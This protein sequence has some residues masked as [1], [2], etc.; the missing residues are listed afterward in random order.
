MGPRRHLR[1]VRL[2]V[3]GV[4]LVAW[5]S[6]AGF[7][8]A[9]PTAVPKAAGPKSLSPLPSGA[10]ATAAPTGPPVDVSVTLVLELPKDA[11]GK[12]LPLKLGDQVVASFVVEAPANVRVF[13][14]SPPNFGATYRRLARIATVTDLPTAAGRK[15][16]QHSWQL[17]VVRRGAKRL[18]SFEVPWRHVDGRTGSVQTNVIRSR[19]RGRLSNEQDPK[20][21]KAPAPA[22]V[23]ATNWALIWGLALLGSALLAGLL[24]FLGL[25]VYRKRLIALQP[26]PPPQPANVAALEKLDEAMASTLKPADRYAEIID[27]LR[28]YLGERYGFDGLE[29]TTKEMRRALDGAD[30]GDFSPY[31]ITEQ[32]EDADLVKF[33]RMSPGEGE[34]QGKANFVRDLVEKT[35]Q[36]PEPDTDEDMVAALESA[37]VRERLIAG[38]VD[39]GVAGLVG[40][41]VSLSAWRIWGGSTAWLGLV[42]YAGLVLL[43]DVG[44]VTSPGKLSQ[45]LLVVRRSP[46]QG[47]ANLGQRIG[48]NILLALPLGALVE[49]LMLLYHP[50]N[51]RIGEVWSNTEVVRQPTL[52][53]RHGQGSGDKART[54]RRAA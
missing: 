42:A 17:L 19:I 13:P 38:A 30:L 12:V 36:A 18:N 21:G 1:G 52:N 44:V 15:K 50:L 4:M 16:E 11:S 29:T 23:V 10:P 34:S 8:A 27:V 45:A 33:A 7:A 43:R 46:V 22:P 20:L 6:G 39:L 26:T 25:V 48:R 47:P 32:L 31:Q 54:P 51:V 9:P 53:E 2:A 41:L 49:A 24:T 28:W 40:L 14:P 3:Y 37:S 35:W 5:A